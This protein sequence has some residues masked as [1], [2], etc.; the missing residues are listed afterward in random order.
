MEFW[1]RRIHAWTQDPRFFRSLLCL[2]AALTQSLSRYAYIE[3]MELMHQVWKCLIVDDFTSWCPGGSRIPLTVLGFTLTKKGCT[4]ALKAVWC[5]RGTGR[6]SLAHGAL[7]SDDRTVE[8]A[9]Q[10]ARSQGSRHSD[11]VLMVNR[12]LSLFL[13]SCSMGIHTPGM[14]AR[15]VVSDASP[16]V[17]S[18]NILCVLR[19]RGISYGGGMHKS[20]SRVAN[21]SQT[22]L[23]YLTAQYDDQL[24]T[25][26]ERESGVWRSHRELPN[27]HRSLRAQPTPVNSQN[28]VGLG[29]ALESVTSTV[30]DILIC[31]SVSAS[32]MFRGQGLKA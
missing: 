16:L 24:V 14:T 28:T 29:V 7:G 2:P 21:S 10:Q 19:D 4:E 3:L 13:L 23:G 8:S 1:D 5:A 17:I 11:L 15:Y 6:I 9:P 26:T 32:V 31:I 25:L 30:M 27:P 20:L 18:L 12:P 22:R